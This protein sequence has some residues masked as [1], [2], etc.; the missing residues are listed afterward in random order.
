MEKHGR[1]GLKHEVPHVEET[2]LGL[3]WAL[4]LSYLRM[5]SNTY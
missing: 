3:I 4:G 2:I 5:M 1:R